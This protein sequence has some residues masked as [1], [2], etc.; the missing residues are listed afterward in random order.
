MLNGYGTLHLDTSKQDTDVEDLEEQVIDDQTKQQQTRVQQLKMQV[1]WRK[2]ERW[3][4][5]DAM[6]CF[7][8]QLQPFYKLL[9][10]KVI[11][12]FPRFVVTVSLPFG[13][14]YGFA[15]LIVILV[16]LRLEVVTTYLPAPDWLLLPALGINPCFPAPSGSHRFPALG[17]GYSFPRLKVIIVLLPLEIVTV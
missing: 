15:P 13:V 14:G 1:L 4:S 12:V 17:A 5:P 3:F 8:L 11:V 10:L 6:L 9:C 16:F 2:Y 7:Y